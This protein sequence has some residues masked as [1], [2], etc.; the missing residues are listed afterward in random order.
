MR[1]RWGGVL[2]RRGEDQSEV[3]TTGGVRTNQNHDYRSWTNQ[4]HESAGE[5]HRVPIWGSP[6]TAG[7]VG[8]YLSTYNEKLLFALHNRP[9]PARWLAALLRADSRS[10]GL[11]PGQPEPVIV[12][13]NQHQPIRKTANHRDSQLKRQPIR[14]RG[15]RGEAPG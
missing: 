3:L 6:S 13:A 2:N 15:F 14:T 11:L 4:N 5:Y 8:G 1:R 7:L 12:S 10:S 9:F